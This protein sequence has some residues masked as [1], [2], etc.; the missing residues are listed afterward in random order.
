MATSNVALTGNQNIDGIL[1]GVRWAGGVVTYA[2]P[3]LASQY[4]GYPWNHN[5]DN[6]PATPPISTNET[7]GLT[8]LNATQ[9][10]AAN[11]AFANIALFT[12]L[13]I[14]MV[15]PPNSADIKIAESSTRQSGNTTAYAFYPGDGRDGDIWFNPTD[16]NNPL[17]GTYAYQTFFHEIGHAMGL[18]HGHEADNGNANVLSADRDSLEF[19]TMTY[20]SYPGAPTGGYSVANGH[21]PQTYMMLDILALQTMY[22]A[23]YTAHSGNTVYGFNPTNAE[24]TI[25]GSGAQGVPKLNNGTDSNV[26]FRTVWDGGG[27]DTYDFSAYGANRQLSIDLAPGGWTDVDSDSN[28]Q[29]ALLGTPGGTA[30][31]AVGQVFNA[32]LFNNNTASLI[33]NAI[34]GAGNDHIRGN[35]ANNTLEGRDGDDTLE[36]F[37]GNDWLYQ[38][39]GG[40]GMYGGNGDDRIVAG[41][42]A[43]YIDGGNQY[44]IAYYTF[45]DAPVYIDTTIGKVTGGWAEGDTLVGLEGLAGSAY[46]DNLRMGGG[47]DTIYGYAGDDSIDGNGGNDFLYGEG[48]NDTLQGGTGADYVDGGPGFD[49]AAF[50]T[51][52]ALNFSTGVHG[53]EAAGD[54][55]VGIEGYSGSAAADSFVANAFG[56]AYFLGN[57]GDDYFSGS[58]FN[59]Y[60][61]GGKGQDTMNGGAGRDMASYADAPGPVTVQLDFVTPETAGKVIAGEWGPDYFTSIE[62]IEGSN[63]G[64][65]LLGDS[66]PNTLSGLGG[67][68]SLDGN[69]GADSLY[70]GEGDDRIVIRAGTYGDGGNGVDTVDF[71]GGAVYLNYNFGT[72]TVGGVAMGGLVNA[73]V[74]N[75][76]VFNDQMYGANGIARDETFNGGDGVDWLW[77]GAGTDWVDGGTGDD[78]LVGQDGNDFLVIGAGADTMDGGDG[79]DTMVMPRA[80][81]ADWQSGVLDADIATDAWYNW[82]AIQGSSGADVIKTNSWGY[83]VVLRGMGGN[84]TLGSGNSNDT[85]EGGDGNDWLDADGGDDFLFGGA[86]DDVL[87]IGPGADWMD[88]GDGRD[89]MLFTMPMV[90]NWQAGLLDPDIGTDSWLNWEVIQGSSGADV[91]KTNSWGFDVELRGKGGADVLATGDGNDT[92]LPGTFNDFADGGAG[93][94]TV[95]YEDQLNGVTVNLGV[96]VGQVTVAAGFDTLLNFENLTG[97]AGN[98]TLKGTNGA[99]VIKGLGGNDLIEALL[100]DDTL[101]G[102]DGNDNLRPWLGND[103]VDGGDGVDNVGWVGLGNNVVVDLQVI[104]PQATGAGTQTILNVENAAG[105]FG[106]DT[107]RGTA[108]DNI[109]IGNQGNDVLEGRGGNDQL[110]GG[111]G[112]DTLR[113]GTGGDIVDGADGVDLLS[114][115]DLVLPVT[116]DLA[117]TTPQFLG[118]GNGTKTVTNVENLSGGSG[119][120]TLRGTTGDNVFFGNDGND[121]IDAREGNDTLNGQNGNDNLRPGLGDDIVDGGNDIDTVGY[122]GLL[123]NVSV[124]LAVTVAQNTGGAGVDRIVNVENV[125][126]GEGADV[127]RG[128]AGANVIFGN[129]GADRIEGRGGIDALTG[130]GGGDTFVYR[131]LADAS[132]VG[133]LETINDFVSGVDKFDLGAFDWDTATAGLQVFSFVSGAFSAAGQVRFAAGQLQF[134]TDA[135]GATL[136]MAIALPGVASMTAADVLTT[137]PPAPALTPALAGAPEAA[138]QATMPARVATSGT[139]SVLDEPALFVGRDAATPAPV[140]PVEDLV[141]HGGFDFAGLVHGSGALAAPPPVTVMGGYLL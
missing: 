70:G 84:D 81:V 19:S 66:G 47:N 91:I 4:T 76:T 136:E 73:E 89:T 119:N 41:N 134:N 100:G 40:G 69:G 116:F 17:L 16:Y 115:S 126:G 72:S 92:I 135:N 45:S 39:L 15:D 110:F 131:S 53:G 59:D 3:T 114:F 109:L 127:L 36:G 125:S 105:G 95:S 37:D 31:Y 32:L 62:D 21:Y 28:F 97:G 141:D 61:R 30:R 140:Q 79:F 87:V 111:T 90:A 94:D 74:Y 139:R 14:L 71:I 96:A 42:G 132:A 9:Q 104:T 82:E 49:I 27:V 64:D 108:G 11:A 18:K 38:G 34:G 80:M 6:N 77:G 26:L 106:N 56:P 122:V 93:I 58:I 48:D 60:F 130:G 13:S 23:D 20:R 55:F 25:S 129:G 113:P 101:L 29:A 121:F 102:G 99:N 98:D 8:A 44:D 118:A 107:L 50:A 35:Q 78:W 137:P 65:T 103:L 120:D 5:H 112:N 88:G 10:A 22:G 57:D 67:A 123:A 43:D 86:D 54:T 7:T 1:S 2:F 128:T 68:D 117:I 52:V 83:D 24:M 138:S 124:D 85:L 33:E 51:A 63:F 75:G 12:N 46:G 133:P